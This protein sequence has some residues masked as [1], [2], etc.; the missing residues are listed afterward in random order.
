MEKPEE[1]QGGRLLLP[2][3]V[4]V[5]MLLSAAVIA[6]FLFPLTLLLGSRWFL[7]LIL[8]PLVYIAWLTLFL[9]ICAGGSMRIGSTN[10]KP[11][12]GTLQLGANAK[13]ALAPGVAT[14]I[15]CMIRAAFVT[16][17]PLVHGLEQF[18]WFRKLVLRSYSPSIHIGKDA[19][20]WGQI[21]DPDLTHIGDRAV[22]GWSSQVIAHSLTSRP[23][24]SIAYVSSPIRIGAGATIGGSAYVA[25]GSVIGDGA[26][27]EPKSY[28]APFTVIP[29]GETW[30]GVP[31][32]RVR[33]G[34]PVEY[35]P[36]S[37]P[38]RKAGSFSQAEL[39]VARKLVAFALG[40]TS[41]DAYSDWSAD[42]IAEWD[43]LGQVAIATAL[44]DVHAVTVNGDRLFQLR[45]LDDV[46]GAIARSQMAPDSPAVASAA[47]D[48]LP[49]D[50]EMLPLGN[51][52]SMTR[53]LTVRFSD[54]PPGVTHLRVVVAS[55]FTAQPL[56]TTMKVWGR[57]FG[58][59]LE[60]EFAGFGQ[61][62]QALLSADSP[63]RA[64]SS[65]V[66]VVLVDCSDRIFASE[67]AAGGIAD[68]LNA[69]DEWKTR[70]PAG[71][72]TLIG[73]L[74]PAV[75]GSAALDRGEYERLRQEWRNRIEL[76][77]H[78]QLFEFGEVVEQIGLR[79]ARNSE[80]DAIARMPYSPS[81]YQALAI[82]LV[83]HI[84]AAR[85][86]PA[87][88]VAVDCDNTLWGGVI[89][90]SGLDGILLSPD[91]P[92]EVFNSFRS[93]SSA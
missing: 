58:L 62:G 8:S 7:W 70:Q 34:T 81:M 23:D 31:A 92:A 82:A 20:V 14:I 87:K 30:G 9:L 76:M 75:T 15:V 74:P 26:I 91:G 86:T 69:I 40:I 16:S 29:P 84:L 61:I 77:S 72:Q 60:C 11:R 73:T 65:G 56:A 71:A 44:F 66:N 67:Q 79:A 5:P 55:S 53:A 3:I 27:V 36:D 4:L 50:S 6:G 22:I 28:V 49:D 19:L 37:Q 48:V 41:L 85:R 46:A 1:F 39:D 59:E 18:F 52:E 68:L 10:P 43:S 13:G 78:V 21:M 47:P 64:N 93:I 88:V 25:L 45:T 42:S 32:R 51:A 33:G 54:S 80:G 57:A 12:Y 90:E 83:R 2:L 63:F 38:I 89:G 35:P 24:G 17:L